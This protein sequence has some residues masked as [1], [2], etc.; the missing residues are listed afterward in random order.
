M[1][2]KSLVLLGVVLASLLLLS[3]DVADARELTDAKESEEKNVKPTRGPG[4]T[5]DEKWGGGNKHDGGYGNGGG[6]KV[7][8]VEK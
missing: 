2:V 1:A 3:E 6:S 5:K 4:L 8:K 7:R